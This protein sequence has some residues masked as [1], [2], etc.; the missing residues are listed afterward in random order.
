LLLSANPGRVS[1][2]ATLSPRLR[3]PLTAI[4]K[5]HRQGTIATGSD[6]GTSPRM[7]KPVYMK[8]I[9]YKIF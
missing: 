2:Q 6:S 3:P 5:G 1:L 8:Y 4:S 9:M 7:E